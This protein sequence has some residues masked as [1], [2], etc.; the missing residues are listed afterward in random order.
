A[1]KAA[2]LSKADLASDMVREFTELQGKMGG[3]YA[4]EAGESEAVWKAI[5]FH[6]EPT[7]VELTAPPLS[8]ALGDAKVSWAAVALADKFDTLTG[9]F[10]AGERPTGSRD[11]FGLRRQAHGIL[12]VLLD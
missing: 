1:A 11:P 4:R 2:R 9:L 3:I 12:R 6:Y 8:D 7:C 10:L 5:C